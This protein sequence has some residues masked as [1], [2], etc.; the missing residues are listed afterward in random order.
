[1][2]GLHLDH[3][4]GLGMSQEE[5]KE[6]GASPEVVRLLKLNGKRKVEIILNNVFL[7]S[8]RNFLKVCIA[9]F[10]TRSLMKKMFMKFFRKTKWNVK[11]K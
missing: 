9:L 11:K 3:L 10:K 7:R 2:A 6:Y 8:L 1:L 4:T 5:R